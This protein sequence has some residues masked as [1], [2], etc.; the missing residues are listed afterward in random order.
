METSIARC[1]RWYRYLCAFLTV[2]AIASPGALA[3]PLADAS[4]G[5][6]AAASYQLIR[7]SSEPTT[8]ARINARGQVVFNV[9]R[10]NNRYHARFHDGRRVR[11]L[12]T[13]GGPGATAAD[14]NQLRVRFL[15][16]GMN[17]CFPG[18]GEG[19]IGAP[20]G[21]MAIFKRAR[22]DRAG[23]QSTLTW[24]RPMAAAPD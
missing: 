21:P 16:A 2:L 3:Q 7:L 4:A 1:R 18:R 24:P 23:R 9:A 15:R 10:N 13:L 14:L 6:P 8:R 5:K 12:G 20:A 19:L 22:F 17:Q 11:D